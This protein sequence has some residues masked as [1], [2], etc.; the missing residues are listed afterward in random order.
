MTPTPS[1]SRQKAEM[2]FGKVQSQVRA[3]EERDSVGLAREEKT[4][5]L[6]EARLAREIAARVALIPK[7]ASKV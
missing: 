2:A 5:R 3:I 7:P 6:R 4:L 1:K